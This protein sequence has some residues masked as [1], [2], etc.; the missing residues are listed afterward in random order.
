M[1][2]FKFRGEDDFCK[3]TLDI[4]DKQRLYCADWTCLND[5]ME[6]H[7]LFVRRSVADENAFLERLK[8]AKHGFKVC[9]LSAK[10]TSRLMW[11]HYAAGFRG[12][13]IE[14]DLPDVDWI[15][16]IDYREHIIRIDGSDYTCVEDE[17]RDILF[18]KYK[19]WCYEKEIRIQSS[20]EFYKLDKPI[21]RVIFGNRIK[22]ENLKQLETR[23]QRM[24]FIL[25]RASL[26][27]AGLQIDPYLPPDDR[28]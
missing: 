23:C 24:Q 3:H 17:A 27:D 28:D 20:E 19:V 16:P 26:S 5:P 11:G 10:F 18:T 21:A 6:A 12:V 4:I 25:C 8:R 15:K 14:V 7:F 1:V 2:A 22:P 13:A 9:S